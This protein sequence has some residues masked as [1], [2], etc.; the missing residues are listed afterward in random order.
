MSSEG[1]FHKTFN[2][3]SQECVNVYINVFPLAKGKPFAHPVY[4][5]NDFFSWLCSDWFPR[6][7]L[8]LSRWPLSSFICTD[9]HIFFLCLLKAVTTISAP[10]QLP[11]DRSRELLMTKRN[12][13]FIHNM[14]ACKPT[15]DDQKKWYLTVFINFLKC[16][17]GSRTCSCQWPLRLQYKINLKQLKS[18]WRGR[19]YFMS[20]QSE[21]PQN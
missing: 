5:T 7:F 6:V 19:M 4:L 21:S 1:Y 2:S 8:F 12:L 11:M 17:V 10:K 15:K 18:N 14:L 20:I 3:R 13:I 9:D 16:L